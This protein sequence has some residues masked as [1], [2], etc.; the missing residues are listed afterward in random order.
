MIQ[1]NTPEA[2]R[3]MIG[4]VIINPAAFEEASGLGL[5]AD[6]FYVRPYG[7]VW[8][9]V[10]KLASK[11]L[12]IDAVSVYGEAKASGISVADIAECVAEVPNSFNAASYAAQIIGDASRRQIVTIASDLVKRSH[13][14][15]GPAQAA[16]D[17]ARELDAVAQAAVTARVA[18]AEDAANEMYEELEDWIINRKAP[19]IAWP[20]RGLNFIGGRRRK[21]LA[22]IAGRPGM[23]K[24]SFAG[25][26]SYMDAR[27][28]LRVS[29][30]TLEMSKAAWIEQAIL[31]DLGISRAK[32][33]P[34]QLTRIRE[35]AIEAQSLPMRFYERGYCT[36]DELELNVKLHAR[37]LGGL[38][39]IFVDHLGYIDHGSGRI[40]STAYAIGVTTK[41]LARIA[42]DLDCVVLALC[43]LNRNSE[44][45]QREPRLID[46]RD[47][48]EIEQDA[49]LVMFLHRPAYRDN[50]D[51][52][53][54]QDNTP[55]VCKV[56]VAKNNNGPTLP[57]T[58]AF[59]RAMR[60]FSEYDSGTPG[61]R[62]AGANGRREPVRTSAYRPVEVAGDDSSY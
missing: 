39:V 24:S 47:S 57:L 59:T 31:A 30:C 1:A 58:M 8:R 42:K 18:T 12:P 35:R 5:R 56:I 44:L 34:E 33:T 16:A 6:M 49:R 13:N 28:G 45:T 20:W 37:D 32:A 7:E 3:A 23:G 15:I 53:A 19:G 62:Q 17:A 14:G 54:E 48:G 26:M 22:V 38:D 27:A 2:E 55:E 21:E 4:S 46:L 25:Q 29:V 36:P 51:R 41:R 40:G 10:G 61:A 60:R 9:A 52:S 50:E 43:Q 11:G